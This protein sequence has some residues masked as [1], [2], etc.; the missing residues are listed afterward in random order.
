MRS[1]VLYPIA[2]MPASDAAGG[3]SQPAGTDDASDRAGSSSEFVP[4]ASR[5]LGRTA[6]KAVTRGR[7][8]APGGCRQ[9]RGAMRNGAAHGKQGGQRCRAAAG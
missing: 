6:A 4:P 5:R 2:D 1:L 3:A 8:E 9:G 7:R